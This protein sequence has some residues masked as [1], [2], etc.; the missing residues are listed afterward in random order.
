M[1]RNKSNSNRKGEN[2]EL[3]ADLNSEY[4]DKRKETVKKVIANMTIGK[5]VSG[6]FA[7]VVKNMQTDD[8]EL[9]KLV[10]LYLVRIFYLK[11]LDKLC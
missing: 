2:Y 11:T 9:K 5:D 8:I 3:K 4:S 1:N 10:Y 7:D 6:L